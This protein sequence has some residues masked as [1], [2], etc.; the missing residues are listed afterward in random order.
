[1][2]SRGVLA[3]EPLRMGGTGTSGAHS[4]ASSIVSLV[5]FIVSFVIISFIVIISLHRV[6]TVEVDSMHSVWVMYEA[7]EQRSWRACLQRVCEPDMPAAGW[8]AVSQW[9]VTRARHPCF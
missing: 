9:P 2:L 5:F 3:S 1:M 6:A 4:L 7:R 8:P